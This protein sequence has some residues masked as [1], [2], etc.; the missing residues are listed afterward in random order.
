MGVGASTSRPDS[1]PA[2]T[3]H[4]TLR[5]QMRLQTSIARYSQKVSGKQ[6][7]LAD[8]VV[9]QQGE[10]IEAQRCRCRR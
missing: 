2:G 5:E 9:A 3:A 4:L 7:L 8:R 6:V 10:L 1:R